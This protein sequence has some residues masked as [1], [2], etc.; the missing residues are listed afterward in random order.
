MELEIKGLIEFCKAI[1]S[2]PTEVSKSTELVDALSFC[3]D[4]L[5]K[6]DCSNK[7]NVEVYE[8]KYT[9]LSLGF[10]KD[11]LKILEQILDPNLTYSKIHISFPNTNIKITV[12]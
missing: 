1:S 7:V 11:T 4:A 6:C 2:S 9:Q 3:I 5:T 12:K 10:S 8:K